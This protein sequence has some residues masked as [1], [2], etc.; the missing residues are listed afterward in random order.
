MATQTL[1]GQT[2]EISDQLYPRWETLWQQISP[3]KARGDALFTELIDCYSEPHRAY[4]NL[5]HIADCLKQF[6][7]VCATA[8]SALLL[9]LAIWS[10]DVL[11][12]PHAKDNEAKSAQWI[13]ERLPAGSLLDTTTLTQL[14]IATEHKTPPE[15]PD[16]QLLVDI[17]LSIL[18]ST[19]ARFDA[20]ERQIREEYA[21]VPDDKFRTGR[22][23]VLQHFLAR[24]PIY[25]TSFFYDT[26]EEVARENIE[27]SL[28]KLTS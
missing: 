3:E 6:D 27:R 4:H 5:Q 22:T 24:S 23:A 13:V 7:H 25:N 11:Y 18:G 14:I 2:K 1:S 17:D 8:Q 20:Y 26:Y 9:E 15:T 19:Q 12:D 21:F 10:H 28:R 16:A